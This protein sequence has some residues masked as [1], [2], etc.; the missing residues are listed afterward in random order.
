MS[1]K[2]LQYYLHLP[3]RIV[4]HPADEGGYVVEILEL[5]GC[6]SQGETIEENLNSSM[7]AMLQSFDSADFKEGVSHYMEKREPKFTGK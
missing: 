7:A 1:E 5:P 2:D 3:Y 6:L 4:L